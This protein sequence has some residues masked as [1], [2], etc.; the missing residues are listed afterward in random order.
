M[1]TSEHATLLNG[2]AATAADLAPLAF[3]GFAHFTAMQLRG[4]RVRGLDHHLDRLRHASRRMFG[5][6]LADDVVRD[7]LREAAEAAEAAAGAGPDHSLTATMFSRVGEFTPAG[8]AD[9]P[10]ILV[11]TAPPSD[12]PSGPLRLD[13]VR[14][15][16]PLADIK[17]VGESTKTLYLREAVARGFDD[18]AYV[19]A[20]GRLSE[21]TIWNL[22][23]WDGRA[24][25]WPRAEMLDGITQQIVRRQLQR[26]GVPQ[27]TAE[28]TPDDAARMAGAAVMNSWTPGVPVGAIG[29]AAI[30]VAGDF[31]QLLQGAYQAEPAVEV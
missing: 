16:R 5:A 9:D 20:D 22:V 1:S 8:A 4:G 21:A 2:R 28:L 18:A 30:P 27:R 10:A 25:V 24:V 6:A 26:S 17:Q 12:G 11:R 23:F 19:D 7:R 31:M 29:D 13:A 14:H 3:A 15:T